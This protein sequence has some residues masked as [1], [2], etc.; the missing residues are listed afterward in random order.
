[1]PKRPRWGSDTNL[2]SN[3]QAT[4]TYKDTNQKWGEWNHLF[5]KYSLQDLADVPILGLENIQDTISQYKVLT[6]LLFG[7]KIKVSNF[8]VFQTFHCIMFGFR[9]A[10]ASCFILCVDHYVQFI[11][12]NST[13]LEEIMPI[14]KP[15]LLRLGWIPWNSWHLWWAITFSVE[16]NSLHAR[17]FL[18][19]CPLSFL[20]ICGM[21]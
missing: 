15:S 18:N 20:L 3:D 14:Q 2:T 19:H 6:F 1:M 21:L 7:L 11:F 17:G 5:S 10:F 4:K 16:L 13:S 12:Q 8:I 9:L